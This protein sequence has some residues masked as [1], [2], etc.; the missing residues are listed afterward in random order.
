MGI[1]PPRQLHI[2][3]ATD[4]AKTLVQEGQYAGAERLIE[5]ALPSGELGP[6]HVDALYLLAVAQRYQEKF[7]QSLTTLERLQT[8]NPA[9]G[10]GFQELGHTLLALK[11]NDEARR[12]YEQ[13]AQ[14]NPALP[15]SWRALA[16]LY[17][18]G[19]L[20][21][22]SRK[23]KEQE[24]FLTQL[25]KELLSATSMVYENKLQKAE[26]LCRHFLQNNKH[27]IEGMRL[28]AEIADRME[29]L[30]D[31]EFL[32]ESCVEFAP[33][34]ERM[35]YDYAN[36]L[37]KKQKFEKAYE[38]TKIL[39]DI[40][41]AKLSYQ[42]MLANA[43]SGVGKHQEAI[44]IYDDVLRHSTNQNMLYV[45]RGHAQ[46]TIGLLEDAIASYRKAYQIQPDYGDAFWSLA[47]TKTYQFTDSEISH[48][49]KHESAVATPLDDRI[50]LCFA[51]GKAFEDRNEHEKSFEYYEK[52]NRLKHESVRHKPSH[53]AIRTSAQIDVC[54]AEFFEDKEG[55]GF[56][57]PDPIFVVGLPRAGSTLLEQILASHSMVEGTLEL[58]NIIALAQRLRGSRYL[59]DSEGTPH[60]PKVLTEIDNDYF[61]RFGEQYINDTRIYRK[62][63][64]FFIDK[65][66]NNFFHI[67]L[68]KLILPNA[69]VIDARR[70]PMSCCFSGFKQL[71]GQG[72]EF[73]YG[74]TEI[75][76][77]YREYVELMDHWDIVL[78]DFVLRVQHEDVVE[79][80]EAEVRRMLEF[81]GLPFEQACIDFY[82]TE[83]SV[84]TP[85][86]EQV[87]QPIY[88][89]GLEQWRNFEPWLGPL[90]EALG[91]ALLNRY[92]IS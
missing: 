51:L 5:Q 85:S 41:P 40:N 38:Q 66:P 65:N 25:P 68:I 16:K 62:D 10:R 77:Y 18:Q 36:L 43:T 21:D 88:K 26:R 91:P 22:L 56:D 72:Q 12:A 13:A 57:A 30:D 19:R 92:P 9:Y 82:K 7:T 55:L 73:S 89:T 67:G 52:G 83:R 69:K 35:R 8:L 2:D 31:A 80:L 29:V 17:E 33:D 45:M 23:A 39:F 11:R 1:E 63:A 44:S 14:L 48:M 15:A 64:P 49:Q 4:R 90:K 74:L 20:D 75:G 3:E 79:D 27:H 70:H 71:F 81:C 46:K 37:L 32:L 87:R 28:L 78:P 54:T 84:R 58:P 61:R 42:S 60:Y 24:N 76:N 59:T 34:Y 6:D 53:L 86:S 47:N 50:H